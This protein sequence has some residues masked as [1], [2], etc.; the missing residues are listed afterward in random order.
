MAGLLLL[1]I[2]AATA[3]MPSLAAGDSNAAGGLKKLLVQMLAF[4]VFYWL[5]VMFVT[6]KA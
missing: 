2:L 5:V 4:S 3:L 1:S 6:P